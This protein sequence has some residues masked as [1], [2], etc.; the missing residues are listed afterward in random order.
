LRR[1]TADELEKMRQLVASTMEQGAFG[2]T[3]ALEATCGY[4]KTDELIE[5][6]EVVSRYG[7][8]YATHVRGEGDTVLDSVREAIE[9]GEKANVP[10]EVFHLK[11]AGKNNWGRMPEVAALIEDARARGIDVNANQYP[12]VAAYHPMLPLL[13]PWAQ[14]GGV[15]KTMERLR[16]SASWSYKA[17]HRERTSGLESELCSTVGRMAGHCHRGNSDGKERIARWQDT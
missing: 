12:Y 7:G 9:I 11:V 14:D 16:H 13:P 15:D 4:A 5:L 17:E 6:A 10:V 8:I 1:P 2:L 3:N